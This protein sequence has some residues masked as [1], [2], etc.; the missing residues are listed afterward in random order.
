MGLLPL[1]LGGSNVTSESDCSRYGHL[2]MEIPLLSVPAAP[3][4]PPEQVRAGE[5]ALPPVLMLSSSPGFF[6]CFPLPIISLPTLCALSLQHL[7]C[8]WLLPT[9]GQTRRC[10]PN[11]TTG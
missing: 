1:V 11:A 9:V 2:A 3:G 8:W 10:E 7:T 4:A 5:L 6:C